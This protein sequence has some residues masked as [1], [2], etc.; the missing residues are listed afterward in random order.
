M[1]IEDIE[2]F[3]SLFNYSLEKRIK[4]RWE[5]ILAIN[6]K[7]EVDPIKIFYLSNEKFIAYLIKKGIKASLKEFYEFKS[8]AFQ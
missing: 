1:S 8:M 3:P 4:P 2:K 5:Y 7:I 6:D